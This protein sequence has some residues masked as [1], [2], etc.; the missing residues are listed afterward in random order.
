MDTQVNLGMSIDTAVVTWCYPCCITVLS[1]LRSYALYLAGEKRKE[2][3]IAEVQDPASWL[4][5]DP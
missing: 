2:E 1:C 5:Y 4:P 3:E